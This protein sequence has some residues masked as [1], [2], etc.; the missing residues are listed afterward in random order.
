MSQFLVRIPTVEYGYVEV[1]SGSFEEFQVDAALAL[2][3]VDGVMGDPVDGATEEAV[4]NLADG[5][6]RT[7]LPGTK[8]RW[9]QGRG[10][11]TS[12]GGGAKY[13]KLGADPLTGREI[14]VEFEGK[15]GPFVK[16]GQDNQSLDKGEDPA[17][18]TLQRAA[19]LLANR[20]AY[21]ASK[22]R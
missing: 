9:Q 12:G 8:P 13:K 15:Y 21:L 19:E 18:V 1:T 4:K 14:T 7:E 17:T 22:G 16:D 3:W 2:D 5:G 6:V 20:R 10:T 11:A